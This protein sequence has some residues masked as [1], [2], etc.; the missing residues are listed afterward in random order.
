MDARLQKRTRCAGQTL[1]VVLSGT[2]EQ[3]HVTGPCHVQGGRLPGLYVISK[4]LPNCLI[5]ETTTHYMVHMYVASIS[6]VGR[7]V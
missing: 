7:Q 4:L 2:T 1:S 6:A 3:A 5:V